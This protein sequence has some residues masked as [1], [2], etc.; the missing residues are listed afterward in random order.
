MKYSEFNQLW[1]S[2]VE[3]MFNWASETALIREHAEAKKSVFQV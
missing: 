1:N 3:Y 2:W